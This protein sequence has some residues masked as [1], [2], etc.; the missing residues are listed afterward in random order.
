MAE[1]VQKKTDIEESS[2]TQQVDETEMKELNEVFN[3]LFSTRR[4]KDA[5]AGLSSGL[6]SVAKG[7]LAGA[8]SLVAQPIAGAQNDGIRG[9][10]SGLA[11][12]VASAVALPMT[13]ICVGAVQ[14]G[15]GVVN[16]AEAIRSAKQGKSW[17]QDK[18]VWVNY[19]LDKEYE[20]LEKAING[21]DGKK[22]D[23]SN[24]L[25]GTKPER[26]VKDREYYDLLQISTNSS[27]SEIKKAYYREARKV[28]PDKC[29]NDP[30]AASKFQTLGSAYQTLSDEQKRATYDK[31]G[32]PEK[33]DGQVENEIDPHVFFNVMF[34][35]ALVEPYIGELWIATTADTVIKDVKEEQI[36]DP[37]SDDTK[38]LA[39]RLA[40]SENST[41]RQRWR[42]VK[43]AINLSKRIEPYVNG[44]E[45]I[46]SFTE[47][48]KK[49]AELIGNGAYGATFLT[50]MGHTM[51]LEADEYLGFQSSFLGIEGHFART[52]KKM[53]SINNNA[54]IFGAGIRAA[55]AGRRAYK[56]VEVAQIN[57]QANTENSDNAEK[58]QKTEED[59]EVAQAMA[60]A[61]SLEQSLPVILELVWAINV[62]DISQTLKKSSKKLF[63]D[64]SRS[65]DGRAKRGE[66]MRILGSIF[67]QVGKSLGGLTPQVSDTSDIKARAEVAVMTTMAKAQGQEVSA[68]DTEEMIHQ[69]KTMSAERKQQE[70]QQ[71]QQPKAD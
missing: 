29:P 16:S 10:F 45:S 54:T 5:G 68:E 51:Q 34:G 56:D 1:I 42:E 47:G 36:F 61:A 39:S 8:A 27:Q 25:T 14:V 62:R 24:N 20:E 50:T 11:T 67:L 48:C 32:K 58:K 3:T 40:S 71:Q 6:K 2:E 17:D 28:H 46:E 4:P 26:T 64:A 37:E 7:T 49:E 55:R 41:L 9:F 33:N 66:A 70:E 69:A 65:L 60:A 13:G 35:S 18:R 53:T 43:C 38:E 19:F 57:A 44:G 21:I 59:E 22:N 31:N 52:K 15:R 12:G 63:A 30:D 23:S